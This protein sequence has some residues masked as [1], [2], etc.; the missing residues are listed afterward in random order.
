MTGFLVNLPSV[1]WGFSHEKASLILCLTA[2]WLSNIGFG[3]INDNQAEMVDSAEC[4]LIQI[5]R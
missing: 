2:C 3:G 5:Q 1:I 4:R